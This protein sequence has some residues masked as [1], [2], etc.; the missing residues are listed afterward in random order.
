M[1]GELRLILFRRLDI[2]IVDRKPKRPLAV[3]HLKEERSSSVPTSWKFEESD[4]S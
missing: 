3:K 2:L 1:C 4:C